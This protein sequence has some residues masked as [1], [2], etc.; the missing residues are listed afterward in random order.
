MSFVIDFAIKFLSFRV[1]PELDKYLSNTFDPILPMRQNEIPRPEIEN[2]DKEDIENP[3]PY[4]LLSKE[5]L[6]HPPSIFDRY[7]S[8]L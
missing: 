7:N 6:Q 1:N 2:E 8:R 4:S 5:G 3:G